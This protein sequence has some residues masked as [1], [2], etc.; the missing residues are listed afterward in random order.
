MKTIQQASLVFLMKEDEVLLAQKKRGYAKG[1]WL[2]VGG[3]LEPYESI[4]ECAV[5]EC[6]EEISVTPLDLEH[7]ATL[8]FIFPTKPTWSQQVFAYATTTWQ[9]DPAESEEMA[10]KWFK[11]EDLPYNA[12]W[13]DAIHWMPNILMGEKLYAEFYFDDN[14]QV[15]QNN[16]VI[17]RTNPHT[18]TQKEGGQNG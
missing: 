12:M 1:K 2:G 5:R 7:I 15:S 9:G 14:L 11:H 8:D 3:K 10:P 6:K 17:G 13:S 4:L 18:Q 16:V